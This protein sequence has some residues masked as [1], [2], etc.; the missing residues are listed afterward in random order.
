MELPGIFLSILYC[1]MSFGFSEDEYSDS[2]RCLS[3]KT[4][5]SDLNFSDKK[6]HSWTFSII[7]F[8]VPGATTILGNS[9]C[10]DLRAISKSA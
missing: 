6:R 1:G 3:D 9:P 4:I 5:D 8:G 2:A 7:S 10:P